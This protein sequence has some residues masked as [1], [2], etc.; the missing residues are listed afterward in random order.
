M[1]KYAVHMIVLDETINK[2]RGSTDPNVREI[3]DIMYRNR[4][5]ATLGC[6]GPDLF[7]WSPDYQIVRVLYRFYEN[8]KWAIDLYNNTIGKVKDAIRAMGEPV[9]AALETLAPATLELIKRLISEIKET[10]NLLKSTLST[11][12]FAGVIEGYDFL[13]QPSELPSLTHSLFDLFVPPLQKDDESEYGESQWYWFDMLHYR[14]TGLFLKNLIKNAETETQKAYAYGY[15]THIATDVVGHGYVN[16]IVGGPY[17]MHP[18]RH[19]TCEN[20]I[21]SWKFYEKYGE[22]INEKLYGKLNL[23]G[24]LPAGLPEFLYGVFLE[25]Y[26]D[27]PHPTR[28]NKPDGFLTVKDIKTTYEVFLFVSEVLGG[29]SVKPPEEPFSGVLDVLN[30]A[31]ERFESPPSPPSGREACSLRD[32]LAF[33]TTERSR[34]CYR[35]FVE[36]IGEWLGYLGEL[37]KWTFE[38]I[39]H[40]IDFLQAALLS[41]PITVAMAV[42]YGVQLALYNLYRSLRSTLVLVGL[43]YPEPDELQTSHGRNMITPYQC[44]IAPF[45]RYPYVHSCALN[46]LQ[47]PIE[48]VEEPGTAAAW[49]PHALSSTPN[50]FISEDPFDRTALEVYAKAQTPAETRNIQGQRVTI[51]NAI[52]FATW[53]IANANVSALEEIVYV[54]WNLDSD[55]G[56]GYKCWKSNPLRLKV[57]AMVT[58]EDYV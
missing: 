57:P 58:G 31:L 8:L 55:R 33:G 21:D 20:F 16:Q 9:E 50:K 30:E 39:L 24:G 10:S 2:L 13:A 44:L 36:A 1:P 32:I 6:I 15:A 22:S 12:L 29:L 48:I 18:Q 56:Y 51:G 28:I 41:L 52:E 42:L 11:G 27:K 26:R 5:A 54:D 25:T 14:F 35:G 17:R 53:L 19:A 34:E 45:K 40:L 37:I 43:L 46:N 38:T 4:Q 3:G 23:P 7:F 49:Y 47:C